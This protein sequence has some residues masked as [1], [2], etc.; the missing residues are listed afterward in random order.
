MSVIWLIPPFFDFASM[1]AIL[2]HLFV[3]IDPLSFVLCLFY[4]SICFGALFKKTQNSRWEMEMVE[5]K[6]HGRPHKTRLV[7]SMLSA[8][9]PQIT[10]FAS[11]ITFKNGNVVIAHRNGEK[12][13]PWDWPVNNNSSKGENWIVDKKKSLCFVPRKKHKKD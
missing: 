9:F 6:L 8:D 2:S 7:S 3:K 11:N 10:F 5:E 4:P 1:Y 12:W 13:H